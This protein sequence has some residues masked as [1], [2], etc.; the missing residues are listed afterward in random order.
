MLDVGHKSPAN[1]KRKSLVEPEA[2]MN[3]KHIAKGVTREKRNTP[4][5]ISPSNS[6]DIFMDIFDD[7]V[8]TDGTTSLSI[9]DTNG[10]SV[11]KK[12]KNDVFGFNN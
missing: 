5:T 12:K 7:D 10:P 3:K 2:G 6:D 1:K 8:I 9:A 11:P 4:K